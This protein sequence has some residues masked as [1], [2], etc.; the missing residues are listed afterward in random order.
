MFQIM[1]HTLEASNGLMESMY[2]FPYWLVQDFHIPNSEFPTMCQEDQQLESEFKALFGKGKFWQLSREVGVFLSGSEL[3]TITATDLQSGHSISDAILKSI[4]VR[5]RS[6]CPR[7]R[8]LMVAIAEMVLDQSQPESTVDRLVESWP[9]KILNNPISAEEKV[10]EIWNEFVAKSEVPASFLIS[11]RPAI[12]LGDLIVL[13]NSSGEG[14]YRQ[15][16][17]NNFPWAARAI[18]KNADDPEEEFRVI[19]ETPAGSKAIAAKWVC[20]SNLSDCEKAISLVNRIARHRSNGE[21]DTLLSDTGQVRAVFLKAYA[22]DP[23]LITHIGKNV[24]LAR[25]QI[26]HAIEVLLAYMNYVSQDGFDCAYS[27]AGLLVRIMVRCGYDPD[28]RFDPEE[29]ATTIAAV[30]RDSLAAF[31]VKHADNSANQTL[32]ESPVEIG[33]HAFLNYVG[34]KRRPRLT[35]N[36]LLN[37]A[38]GANNESREELTLIAAFP[39]SDWPLVPGWKSSFEHLGEGTKITYLTGTANM[40]KAGENC[41]NCLKQGA[42]QRA[43]LL[44]RLSFFLIESNDAI[45]LLALKPIL[46]KDDGG[47]SILT[48][49]ENYQFRGESNGAPNYLI[50]IA[51]D[52]L[53]RQLQEQ[54]PIR[55]QDQEIEKRRRVELSLDANQFNTDFSEANSRWRDMYQKQLPHAFSEVTPEMIVMNHLKNGNVFNSTEN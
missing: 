54:C 42:Y 46:E 43:A 17:A 45:G 21:L 41:N 3:P 4:E 30:S 39:I 10:L 26:T 6:A 49:W 16:F 29:I 34:E 18:F 20:C 11:S 37:F 44:G 27:L 33:V 35:M 36:Q 48:G 12:S 23:E 9:I 15:S 51:G 14:S 24:Q 38:I 7:R 32:G 1:R 52:D 50:L 22:E 13:R 47:G 55:I 2:V 31:V 53:L 8:R 25:R 5:I 19:D 40:Y 28:N